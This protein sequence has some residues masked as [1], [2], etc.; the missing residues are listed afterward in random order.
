MPGIGWP[1]ENQ[2][3]GNNIVQYL[4]ACTLFD[5]QVSFWR[6]PQNR[7]TDAKFIDVIQ[8]MLINWFLSPGDSTEEGRIVTVGPA[9]MDWMDYQFFAVCKLWTQFWTQFCDRNSVSEFLFF[10]LGKR[11]VND[12]D[13]V[14]SFWDLRVWLT[15]WNKRRVISAHVNAHTF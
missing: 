12:I 9:H 8:R 14:I 6:F 5:I 3:T 4:T 10:P 13:Q 1:V 11:K 15:V 2:N 7:L